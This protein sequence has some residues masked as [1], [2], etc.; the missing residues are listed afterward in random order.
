MFKIFYFRKNVKKYFT[1]GKMLKILYSKK[2]VVKYFT[3]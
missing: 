3:L 2:N 1:P